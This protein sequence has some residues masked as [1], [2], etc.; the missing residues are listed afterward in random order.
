MA[1]GALELVVE[2]YLDN[3][4]ELPTPSLDAPCPEGVRELL[5]SVEV[6]VENRLVTTREA[7]KLLGIG[8]ARVRQLILGGNLLARRQEGSNL[9]YLRSALD[10]MR[11]RPTGGHPRAA[12]L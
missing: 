11:E 4:R 12:V 3:G 8:D 6:D 1:A 9:V 2:S 10:R 7:A 5:A